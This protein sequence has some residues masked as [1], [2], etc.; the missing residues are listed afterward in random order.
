MRQTKRSFRR[1][2]QLDGVIADGQGKIDS[3]ACALLS[4]DD[5][6]ALIIGMRLETKG[7][8]ALFTREEL[9]RAKK[10]FGPAKR[11][12]EALRRRCAKEFSR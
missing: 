3:S 12:L 11:N 2:D 1:L 6:T 4:D 10:R 5:L 8:L 7:S 9:E